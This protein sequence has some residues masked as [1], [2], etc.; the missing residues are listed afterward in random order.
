MNVRALETQAPKSMSGDRAEVQAKVAAAS[1]RVN[2]TRKE[3]QATL[4]LTSRDS[5]RPF[6]RIEAGSMKT[7]S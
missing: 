7:K 4:S 2:A 5:V 6:C 1:E 3:L